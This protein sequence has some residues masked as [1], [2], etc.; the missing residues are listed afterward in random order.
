MQ[1]LNDLVG[2]RINNISAY[3]RKLSDNSVCMQ[4]LENE[5]ENDTW[6]TADNDKQKYGESRKQSISS[7]K[8]SHKKSDHMKIIVNEAESI[9]RKDSFEA[10]SV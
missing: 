8:C 9:G 4:E 10:S 5:N 1:M 2:M 6:I 3:K 7:N